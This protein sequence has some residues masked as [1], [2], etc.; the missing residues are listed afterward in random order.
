MVDQYQSRHELFRNRI[1]KAGSDN[2][3]RFD[4]GLAKSLH[5]YQEN[6]PARGFI[7]TIT[8]NDL[9]IQMLWVGIPD[10]KILVTGELKDVSKRNRN[11]KVIIDFEEEHLRSNKLP[12]VC[13]LWVQIKEP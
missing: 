10:Q 3:S 6:L 12:A 7:S 2:P 5:S 9:L 4:K 1:S 11:A 13:F 8:N